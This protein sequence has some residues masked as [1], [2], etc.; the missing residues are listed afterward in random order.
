M[1]QKVD[2]DL[3]EATEEG[4]EEPHNDQE[5]KSQENKQAVIEQAASSTQKVYQDTPK[6]T[7]ELSGELHDDQEHKTKE[8]YWG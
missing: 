5:L 1:Q 2:E 8:H 4:F 3:T 7:D 6:P